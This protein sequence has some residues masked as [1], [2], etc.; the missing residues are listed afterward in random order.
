MAR[1]KVSG[2]AAFY[3]CMSRTV[4]GEHLFDAVAKE[5]LRKQLRQVADF[6]GVEVITYAI[7]ANHFHVLVRVPDRAAISDGEVLRRYRVLYPKPTRFQTARIEVMQEQLKRG[8]ADAVAWRDRQLA[9]M[10][11]LSAFMKLLKQRFSV[12]FNR[13]HQRFGPL[14][15]DRF[16]SVLIEGKRNALRTMAAY[17][18]LNPVRAGLAD[19]PRSY[20]F[21]GYSD[22]V[23]GD[24]RIRAGL[25]RVVG[26]ADW[27][28]VHASYRQ[29]L[30]GV[31]TAARPGA[32]RISDEAF[33]Q[34]ASTR[35][36]LPLA[37]VLRSRLRHFS[38]GLVLGS[39]AFVA[40]HLSAYRRRTGR[41]RKSA[42]QALPAVT[43]WGGLT[44][45]RGVRRR[46]FG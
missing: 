2:K 44:A 43:D 5:V 7:M 4:N 39:H 11:D 8:E 34:V 15:A 31:G 25:R 6:C 10:G 36:E 27:R 29:L 46:A 37:T 33:Q 32:G 14:W 30:F 42:P 16:K 20:R 19:D 12:W 3:H 40:E 1:V 17:I 45:L 24:D 13:T 21:C 18:D 9:L 38:D 28:A 22:A 35:G 23:A 26:G 41:R